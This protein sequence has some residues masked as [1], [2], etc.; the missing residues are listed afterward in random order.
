MGEGVRA[1]FASASS[2]S[3]TTFPVTVTPRYPACCPSMPRRN[4]PPTSRRDH[5]DHTGKPIAEQAVPR[6]YPFVAVR[7]DGAWGHGGP[8]RTHIGGVRLSLVIQKQRWAGTPAIALGRYPD[9]RPTRSVFSWARLL[10]QFGQLKPKPR[11]LHLEGFHA[12]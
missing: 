12:K 7:R 1:Y 11:G 3:P 8:D 10:K 4:A 2:F 5:A 9:A 6:E